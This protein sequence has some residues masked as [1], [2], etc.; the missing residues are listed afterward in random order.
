[1]LGFAQKMNEVECVA[2][3]SKGKRECKEN[4]LYLFTF[5]LSSLISQSLLSPFYLFF[6][7]GGRGS[8]GILKLTSHIFKFNLELKL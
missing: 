2:D 4:N 3:Y 5:D 7:V 1:M 6:L 8:G